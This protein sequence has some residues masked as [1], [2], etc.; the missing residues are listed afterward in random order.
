MT[1]SRPFLDL[2]NMFGR[3]HH[4]SSVLP[5]LQE[6][7]WRSAADFWHITWR[8][9]NRLWDT[10]SDI[11]GTPVL[12]LRCSQ[13]NDSADTDTGDKQNRY[14]LLHNQP[15]GSK[16]PINI[17]PPLHNNA[18]LAHDTFHQKTS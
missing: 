6:V 17:W 3:L 2:Y 11:D 8:Q 15:E 12:A 18:K 5:S 1:K 14:F 9:N 4:I 13:G 10:K 16:R 7:A